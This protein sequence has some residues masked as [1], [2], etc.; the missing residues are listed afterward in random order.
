MG[1]SSGCQA[2]ACVGM[3]KGSPSTR[4][5]GIYQGKSIDLEGKH[6]GGEL[7]LA[8]EREPYILTL[9]RPSPMGL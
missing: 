6:S 3:L 9:G 4:G 7:H 8:I 2:H 5:N 1:A